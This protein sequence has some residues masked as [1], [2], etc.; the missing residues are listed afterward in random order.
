MIKD[1]ATNTL[2]IARGLRR[3]VHQPDRGPGDGASYTARAF[4]GVTLNTNGQLLVQRKIVST[5][6]VN[7]VKRRV[8]LT[9]NAATGQPLFPANYAASACRAVDYGNSV[10]INGGV[11]SNGNITLRNTAEVCGAATPGPGKT[12]TLANSATVCP[13]LP[14]QPG[15]H[16]LRARARGPGHVGDAERQQPDLRADTCT[17]SVSWNAFD[18]HPDPDE[19]RHADAERQRVQPLPARPAEH[20]AAPDRRA[21]DSAAHLLRHSGGVRASSGTPR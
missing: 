2:Q 11:G 9:T 21:I 13:G 20:L 18:P 19:Q 10:F 3:L 5:G 6:T 14:D 16:E 12:L 15:Q 4:R 7:G 17:G 1:V 8:L